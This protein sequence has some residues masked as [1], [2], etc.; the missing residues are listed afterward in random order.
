MTAPLRITVPYPP[1]SMNMLYRH[2]GKNVVL[3]KAGR[4][5]AVGVNEAVSQVLDAG[6]AVP[7]P[8]HAVWLFATPPDRRK[9]DLDNLPKRLLDLVYR[10]LGIDDS[11]IIRMGAEWRR[12]GRAPGVLVDIRPARMVNGIVQLVADEETSR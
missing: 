11:Q 10:R 6:A 8:P 5:Y 2:V 4:E 1:V 12:D 9:R 7:P 3:S